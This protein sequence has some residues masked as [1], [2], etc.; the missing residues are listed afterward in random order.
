MPLTMLP[1]V[2]AAHLQHAAVAL[3]QFD[4]IVSLQDHVVEFKE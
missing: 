2:G 4:K 1:L 3:V